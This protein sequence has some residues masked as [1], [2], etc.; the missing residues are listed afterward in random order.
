M[1]IVGTMGGG[2]NPAPTADSMMFRSGDQAAPVKLNLTRAARV[3]VGR[4][5][6]ITLRFRGVSL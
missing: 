5:A 4:A 6:N 3:G 1:T 2:V